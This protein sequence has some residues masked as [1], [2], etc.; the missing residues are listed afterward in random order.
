MHS[1]PAAP[2]KF[3][4]PFE[5]ASTFSGA[6]DIFDF[7]RAREQL[8][9]S[10]AYR[11]KQNDLPHTVGAAIDPISHPIEILYRERFCFSNIFF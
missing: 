7:T 8:T 5:L 6:L 9:S 1:L 2:E 11:S 3:E 10:D 4:K